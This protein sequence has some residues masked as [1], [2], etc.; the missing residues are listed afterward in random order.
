MPRGVNV[1]GGDDPDAEVKRVPLP[2]FRKRRGL[3]SPSLL[4]SVPFLLLYD[5]CPR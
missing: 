5:N 4:A 3:I 1:V 2:E